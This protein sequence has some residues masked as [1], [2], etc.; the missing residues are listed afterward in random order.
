[1]LR[2]RGIYG[3]ISSSC[4]TFELPKYGEGFR[5]HGWWCEQYT[6][7]KDGKIVKKREYWIGKNQN[8]KEFKELLK[9]GILSQ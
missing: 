5:S 8:F 4:G 1:V 3:A 7:D 9:Q 2:K 6:C